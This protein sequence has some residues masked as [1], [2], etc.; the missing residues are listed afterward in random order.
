M[1][2]PHISRSYVG[3]EPGKDGFPGPYAQ[4]EVGLELY[5]VENDISETR[6]VIDKHPDVVEQLKKLADTIREELGDRLTDVKGKSVRE[7]GTLID[8]K[9]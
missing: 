2:F 5:D 3:A 1:Y 9:L 6:N 7:H 8:E 4:L